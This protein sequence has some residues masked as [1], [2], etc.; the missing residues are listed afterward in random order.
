M[1]YLRSNYIAFCDD[2]WHQFH[3]YADNAERVLIYGYGYRI[4]DSQAQEPLLQVQ[5]A[6]ADPEQYIFAVLVPA[7]TDLC[8]ALSKASSTQEGSL[9]TLSPGHVQWLDT[10]RGDPWLRKIALVL[11]KAGLCLYAGLGV[12]LLRMRQRLPEAALSST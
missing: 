2:A 1:G 12:E 3:P 6:P 8:R 9:E 10:P 7:S 11:S 5:I 4:S